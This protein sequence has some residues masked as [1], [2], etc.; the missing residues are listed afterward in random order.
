MA[1]GAQSKSQPPRTLSA[2]YGSDARLGEYAVALQNPSSLVS[3]QTPSLETSWPK[4]LVPGRPKNGKE[5]RGAQLRFTNDI[6][7]IQRRAEQLRWGDIVHMPFI[8]SRPGDENGIS[9]RYFIVVLPPG[10]EEG[11]NAPPTHVDGI[12]ISTNYNQGREYWS[13]EDLQNKW[14][15]YVN[16]LGLEEIDG[17]S[18]HSRYHPKSLVLYYEVNFVFPEADI[19]RFVGRIKNVEKLKE[20]YKA[21]FSCEKSLDEIRKCKKLRREQRD[22]EKDKEKAEKR[23]GQYDPAYGF[24]PPKNPRSSDGVMLMSTERAATPSY[25]RMVFRRSKSPRNDKRPLL[26]I[27]CRDSWRAPQSTQDTGNDK[28]PEL[29]NNPEAEHSEQNRL[30]LI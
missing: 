30:L 20:K 1:A 27:L 6:P 7:F 14:S 19:W 25:G 26:D 13:A 2:A 10:K 15:D 21:S 8:H 5:N 18:Y 29:L 24:E 9:W 22:R 11:V 16:A 28:E 12:W 3:R 4:T 17:V 23:R